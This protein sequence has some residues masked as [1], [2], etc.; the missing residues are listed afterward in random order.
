MKNGLGPE[1]FP[2]YSI[3]VLA[4][5]IVRDLFARSLFVLLCLVCVH[6][7]FGGVF[8]CRLRGGVAAAFHRSRASFFYFF[9]P[10]VR[11]ARF[12]L[13][14]RRL[15]RRG[16]HPFT[17]S[18]RLLFRL[19]HVVDTSTEPPVM[20]EDDGNGDGGGGGGGVAADD[21]ADDGAGGV[22][23][24]RSPKK[25]KAKTEW[26]ATLRKNEL[27][28]CRELVEA[29]NR[30]LKRPT[31]AELGPTGVQLAKARPDQYVQLEGRAGDW[32]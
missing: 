11:Q 12:M 22:V 19:G 4:V 10:V 8:F 16:R 30:E 9:S 5:V 20:T 17:T 7:L 6:C 25:H 18:L 24:E 13:F 15:T 26:R 14:A 21:A 27:D 3:S 2:C 29:I 31:S 28:G 1:N 32:T 23:G